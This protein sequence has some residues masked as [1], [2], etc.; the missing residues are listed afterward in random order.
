MKLLL[1]DDERIIREHI[2]FLLRKLPDV[3]LTASC[4]N[5]FDALE[6]I[7]NNMPDILLTDIKMPQMN[8]LEL[9]ERVQKMNPAIHC[10]VL[11]GYDEFQFAK[12]AIKLGVREYLLKP[13]YEEE[14][15]E[16][17]S[18]ICQQISAERARTAQKLDQ[19]DVR[20]VELAEQLLSLSAE[21]LSGENVKEQIRLLVSGSNSWD[22][23]R[24][25][26]TYIVANHKTQPERS[27][28]AIKKAFEL[29]AMK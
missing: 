18:R 26:Y 25:A 9:I 19:R 10:L 8:G 27:L 4:A 16:S 24:A 7:E 29:T 13:F 20:I 21:Q 11:S 5:A 22:V 1:V 23:L 12:N 2:E 17:L 15:I 3:I 14:L 28:S 6:S